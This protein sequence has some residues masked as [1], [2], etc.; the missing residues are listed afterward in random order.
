[1]SKLCSVQKLLHY[2]SFSQKK[3]LST[4]DNDMKCE[5]TDSVDMIKMI[6]LLSDL[7]PA[8]PFIQSPNEVD[9]DSPALSSFRAR[10][11]ASDENE[12]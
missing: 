5:F 4:V 1:M 8:S 10:V 7:S 11:L 9:W 12:I 2:T 3:I 6:F